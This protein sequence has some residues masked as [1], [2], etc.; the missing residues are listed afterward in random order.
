MKDNRIFH[1]LYVI[2][3][4]VCRTSF[5]I[6]GKMQFNEGEWE[7]YP[8]V[9]AVCVGN[10]K[11]FGG[12]MKITPNADPFTGNLEVNCCSVRSRWWRSSSNFS[13]RLAKPIPV[14]CSSLSIEV[15]SFHKFC[16]LWF[17]RTSSG[18]I[19]SWNYISFTMGHI[20]QLKMYLQE[21]IIF[22]QIRQY[23]ILDN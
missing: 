14:L 23:T 18:M 4:E 16:R 17:S 20:S 2:A 9:T 1:C 6:Y 3:S 12:G 21:G 11:Y 15:N 8:Q 19:L 13:Y 22:F 7:K 5:I 10:A